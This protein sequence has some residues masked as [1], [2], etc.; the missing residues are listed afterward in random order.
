MVLVM[1]HGDLTVIN[2]NIVGCK[3]NPT[4]GLTCSNNGTCNIHTGKC[5]CNPGYSGDLCETKI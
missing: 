3:W 2:V 5:K 1:V 4:N